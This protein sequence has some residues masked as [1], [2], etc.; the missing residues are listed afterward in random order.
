MTS[1]NAPLRAAVVGCGPIGQLHAQVVAASPRATL[2]GVCDTDAERRRATAAPFGTTSFTDCGELLAAARPD[3]VLI[4]TPDHAH[5]EPALLAIGA[6]CHVFCEKPLATSAAEAERI[7][8]AAA[9]HGTHLA[10]NYNRRYGPGYRQAW[11]W[12][13]RGRIGALD[14]LTFR[15]CD[16]TPPARVARG[17]YVM[18]TTLLVHFLDLAGWYAG[19]IRR[20]RAKAGDAAPGG[21]VRQV[22]LWLET[23]DGPVATIESSYHDEQPHTT[24]WLSLIGANGSIVVED[25]SRRVALHSEESG[26]RQVM[27]QDNFTMEQAIGASI[28]AHVN[29]FL[30]RLANNRPPR[31]TGQDGLV[32]LR[33][34][35][36]AVE[37]LTTGRTI[38]MPA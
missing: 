7:V 9:Q 11:K 21:L 16:P 14:S 36:A 32:G 25:I 6:G 19:A 4:A 1:F 30:N 35:E 13:R 2:V 8:R 33:V 20:V 28:A 38:E 31:I 37:S 18:L 17:P 3:V 22:S 29:D 15:I 34:A 12:L 26:A 27:T 24:E 23:V 5:V 10:V